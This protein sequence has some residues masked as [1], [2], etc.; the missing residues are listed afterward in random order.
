MLP[1]QQ[2]AKARVINFDHWSAAVKQ[3]SSQWQEEV[4]TK[5]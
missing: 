4:A 5:M 2:Y 3:L 1:A